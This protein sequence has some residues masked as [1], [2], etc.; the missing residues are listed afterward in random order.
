MKFCSAQNHSSFITTYCPEDC[1]T[2]NNPFWIAASID[3]AR[4]ASGRAVAI[5]NATVARGGAVSNRSTFMRFEVPNLVSGQLTELKVI[6]TS[7]PGEEKFETC[8]QP[9]T[10]VYLEQQLKEKNIKYSCEEDTIEWLDTRLLLC[11]LHPGS[12][13]CKSLL[14]T[15][16]SPISLKI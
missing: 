7:T 2:R 15:L 14:E 10:L 5:L 16:K 11:F 13:K 8:S 4:R 6:L 1:V 3:F 12:E 9:R